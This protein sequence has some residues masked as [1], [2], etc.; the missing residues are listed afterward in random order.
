[1]PDGRRLFPPSDLHSIGRRAHPRCLPLAR[2]LI[3]IPHP[4]TPMPDRLRRQI[5]WDAARLLLARRESE[6]VRAKLK[7]AR[8]F[9]GG[10]VNPEDLPSDQEVREQV[11]SLSRL[12][13]GD[14]RTELAEMAPSDGAIGPDRF[15]V[16]RL[17]LAPLE[18]IRQDPT[19]HPEGDL[20]THSLQVFDLACDE[21]PYDEEFLAAALLHEVGRGIDSD[22]PVPAALEA[23][24]ETI[25]PRTVWLIEHLADAHALAAG[26][27]GIRPRRRLEAHADFAD[28]MLL[29]QC[30]RRGRQR[31]IE[32]SELD[33]AAN[34]PPRTGQQLRG[35]SRDHFAVSITRAVLIDTG[36]RGRSPLSVGTA[37]IACTTAKL[38]A[39]AVR[40]NAVYLP[41]KWGVRS[42]QMKNCE[43]AEL[44]SFV[45]AIDSTPG[46]CFVL[47]NSAAIM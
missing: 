33:E 19:Q 37:P 32:V 11:Q 40:P 22:N 23:L 42:R 43:P 39:S 35:M 36:F 31:G 13:A 25:T 44:G 7:A 29:A 18:R 34:V 24:G 2:P 10:W 38:A 28:L 46:S 4:L 26:T 9:C 3:P 16:Y 15:A 47:L 30:D 6:Y 17:L 14:R 12:Q 21:Q 27:I 20:L 45:R 8:R 5:A 41:S 1:M